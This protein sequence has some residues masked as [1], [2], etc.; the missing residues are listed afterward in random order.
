M[1]YNKSQR[2]LSQRQIKKFQTTVFDYYKKHGRH[3]L[4][5]RHT[6][7]PYH[8]LVSEI[9]LQQTQVARVEKY[10]EIFLRQFPT[11]QKLARASTKHVLLIWQGLGYNR[12]AIFLQQAAVQVQKN[13]YGTFPKNPALLVTLPGIGKATAGAIC[14]YAYNMPI[15]FIETNIRRV[16]LH[17]FFKNKTGVSDNEIMPLVQQTI[18]Q[19]KSRQWYLALMDY[20]SMIGKTVQ[21]PN[22]QST[23]YAKQ[24]IFEGSRRQVRSHIVKILLQSPKTFLQLKK[25]IGTTQ[26][27]VETI[28]SELLKESLIAQKGKKYFIA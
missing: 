27:Q 4:A 6:K 22:R 14:A 20:G 7:N 13:Y 18:P 1:I 8:I 25:H 12:R 28:L 17:H 2:T 16:F 3:N 9:M 5:W 15:A 21:N 23:H 24:S 26:H 11:C 10:Y 19:K